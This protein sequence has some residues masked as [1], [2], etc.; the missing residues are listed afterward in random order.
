[1]RPPTPGRAWGRAQ[2]AP[3]ARR[4]PRHLAFMRSLKLWHVE[5]DYYFAHA[6]VRPGIRLSE[7]APDDLLWIRDEFLTSTADFGKIVVHGHTITRGPDVRR[8]RIGI[9][10]GAFASNVLTCLV[11][12]GKDFAF[13]HTCPRTPALPPPP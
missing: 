3:P 9:D 2:S 7:Q 11:L 10:T 13:L 6:G 12:N 4:P 8:N 5:G 1:P